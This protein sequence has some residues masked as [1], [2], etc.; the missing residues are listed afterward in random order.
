VTNLACAFKNISTFFILPL[1]EHCSIYIKDWPEALSELQDVV[2][3]LVKF[4][5]EQDVAK[6]GNKIS[7]V[8]TKTEVDICKCHLYKDL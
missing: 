6:F 8:R 2:P 1:G 4:V 5:K 3:D 7:E